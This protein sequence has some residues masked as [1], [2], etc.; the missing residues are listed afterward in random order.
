M[1]PPHRAQGV[2][3]P[4]VAVGAL[5]QLAGM[6]PVHPQAPDEFYLPLQVEV[7]L[8]VGRADLRVLAEA[9]GISGLGV[10]ARASFFGGYS[11]VVQ[12]VGRHGAWS[13]PWS[14]GGRGL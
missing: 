1:L 12:A 6:P 3:H 10:A 8:V 14:A 11:Q 4:V 2:V 7:E 9:D 13:N 5:E